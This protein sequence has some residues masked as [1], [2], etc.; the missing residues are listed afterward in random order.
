ML[1]HGSVPSIRNAE[2]TAR[3][4]CR[5]VSAQRPRLPW[6]E[7]VAQV[8][9]LMPA[10]PVAQDLE[11]GGLVSW[12]PL[13]GSSSRPIRKA[14]PTPTTAPTIPGDSRQSIA[15][16]RQLLCPN[17]R[18]GR[19]ALGACFAVPTY[20]GT[21]PPCCVMR[22]LATV[23]TGEIGHRQGAGAQQRELQLA[24]TGQPACRSL[25][26]TGFGGGRLDPNLC[27]D[28]ITGP[29]AATRRDPATV[30]SAACGARAQ[31]SPY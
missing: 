14:S 16:G 11:A 7:R 26:D 1:P 30:Y 2:A 25:D 31:R 3:S 29:R 6:P 28:H 5:G 12:A 18:T 21:E 27:A 19:L 20:V 4:I 22:G 23:R 17:R 9:F 10:I 15:G 24:W 13:P 8:G